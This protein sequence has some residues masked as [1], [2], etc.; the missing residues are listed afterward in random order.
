[1]ESA[2]V[3]GDALNGLCQW[4]EMQKLHSE[5][6]SKTRQQRSARRYRAMSGAS[7]ALSDTKLISS[8]HRVVVITGMDSADEW[9]DDPQHHQH[10]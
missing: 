6:R 1:M 10:H 5:A 7:I 9:K 3:A 4:I 8:H 2:T